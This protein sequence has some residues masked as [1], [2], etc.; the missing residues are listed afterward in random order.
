MLNSLT[1][2]QF[3]N[4]PLNG[5]ASWRVFLRKQKTR[6]FAESSAATC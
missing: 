3:F 1:T 2:Q 4:A 5:G 6:H